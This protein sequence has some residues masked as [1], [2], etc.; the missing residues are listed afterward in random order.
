MQMLADKVQHAELTLNQI[1]QLI[2]AEHYDQATALISEWQQQLQRIFS[3]LKPTDEQTLQQIEQ[4]SDDFLVLLPALQREQV[5]IK[6]SISQI[7][8]VKSDN[9]ISKIYQID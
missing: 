6:D 8:A 3:Q 1:K 4:L 5:K 7:A 9:K 2:A